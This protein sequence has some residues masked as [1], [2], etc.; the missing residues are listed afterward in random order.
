M[1]FLKQLQEKIPIQEGTEGFRT[2]LREIYR[3]G[4]ISLQ[5]LSYQSLLPIPVLSKIVNF[6][7]LP[8]VVVKLYENVY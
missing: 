1:E 6:L 3:A 4:H 7:I 2:I 8:I 5:D